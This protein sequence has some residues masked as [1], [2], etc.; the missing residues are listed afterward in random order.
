MLVLCCANLRQWLH[1]PDCPEI[2]W[3]FKLLFDKAFSHDH[4]APTCRLMDRASYMHNG[5]VFSHCSTHLGNSLVMYYPL[6]T[7]STPISGS[8]QTIDTSGSQV[9]F[10][11]IIRPVFHKEHMILFINTP[12]FLPH[13]IALKW[14]MV[15]QIGFLHWSLWYLMLLSSYFHLIVLLF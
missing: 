13:S 15:L 2:I 14:M 1:R 8:I 5:V 11:S 4:N 12:H 6:P 9:Y 7:C 3:Q 10:L